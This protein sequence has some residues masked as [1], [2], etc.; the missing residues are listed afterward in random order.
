MGEA[1]PLLFV[2]RKQHREG[3]MLQCTGI[4]IPEA[5][6]TYAVLGAHPYWIWGFETGVN[7]WGVAIGNE[8]E[9][10]RC[11]PE[12]EEGLL[13]MD[14]LRLALERAKTAEE[15]VDVIA[16]L[17]ERYGQNANASLL[18]D[19]RY[20]NSFMICDPEEIWLMETAGRRYAARKVKDFAALSNCYTIGR[21]FD[22]A[23]PDL[24]DYARGNRWIGPFEP[25][26]FA[27]AFTRGAAR[28]RAAVPRWRILRANMEELMKAG[29]GKLSEEDLRYIFRNHFEEELLTPR[30]GAMSGTFASVCMHAFDMKEARTASSM[31]ISYDEE[32]RPVVRYAACYPC[33]SVYL[34]VVFGAELPE[35]LTK[36]GRFFEEDSLWWQMERLA[37]N[38]SADEFRYGEVTRVA[39]AGIEDAPESSWQE[40]AEILMKKAV[41][42]SEQIEDDIRRAG[43]IYGPVKEL[44]LEYAAMVRLPVS[45]A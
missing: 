29:D 32:N 30:F 7:E 40:K 17:L 39:L 5:R 19:R 14:L 23:S 2:P 41:S 15:A 1:Q 13:G 3:E 31:Y 28:Q 26:D 4:S 20:E 10:S 27:K 43:G 8:A 22:K 33:C 21:A 6:E 18:Y 38:V 45:G 36:G 37:V 35:M 24:E 11:P 9:G 12:N 34:P 25:F 42:I 16:A 44:I